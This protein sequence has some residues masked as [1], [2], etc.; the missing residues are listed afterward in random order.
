V[1]VKLSESGADGH[2]FPI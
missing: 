1:T 2:F